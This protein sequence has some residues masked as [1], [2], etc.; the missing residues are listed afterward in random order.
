MDP[1]PTTALESLRSHWPEYLMEGALLGLFMHVGVGVRLPHPSPRPPVRQTVDSG[2]AR[3]LLMGAAM[4]L[5]SIALVHSPWGKRSGAHLNPSL[6]L[7]FLRLGKIDPWDAAFYALAQFAGG[8]TGLAL[9]ALAPGGLLAGPPIRW[10][11]T[12]PGRHLLLRSGLRPPA[13]AP[14]PAPG[15]GLQR[16]LRLD[17]RRAAP[18][19]LRSPG[20]ER[21]GV[22]PR[23]ELP[24]R[25][26]EP[27]APP[28][29]GAARRRSGPTAGTSRRHRRT[30]RSRRCRR[31]SHAGCRRR[32]TAR[33]ASRLP[34]RARRGRRWGR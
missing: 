26:F 19:L 27:S 30:R 23:R 6:T 13:P 2:G 9:A 34:G 32:R 14:R 20:A 1:R 16:G 24:P 25:R 8:V 15:A 28:E 5:I 22:L 17:P 12:L 4:G 11:A 7:A 3:R 10:I 33:E 18:R 29:R 21:A 31:R